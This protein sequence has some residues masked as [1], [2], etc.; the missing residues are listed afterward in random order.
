MIISMFLLLN[1][2]MNYS[3]QAEQCGFRRY[4]EQQDCV[5]L[6]ADLD[7]IPIY[8]DTISFTEHIIRT[9]KYPPDACINGGYLITIDIDTLGY[10]SNIKIVRDLNCAVCLANLFEIL[11]TAKPFTPPKKNDKPVCFSITFRIPYDQ[12]IQTFQSPFPSYLNSIACITRDST[13]TNLPTI[14]T[15]LYKVETYPVLDSLK[16]IVHPK[17]CVICVQ[18]T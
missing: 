11:N 13:C 17:I 4:P 5:K 7:E 1:I 10:I 16:Y 6:F 15:K 12:S 14:D 18:K 2:G 3:Q 8:R 9:L